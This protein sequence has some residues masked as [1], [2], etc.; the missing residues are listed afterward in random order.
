MI[1]EVDKYGARQIVTDPRRDMGISSGTGYEVTQSSRFRRTFGVM[2]GLLAAADR[3]LNKNTL[4]TLRELC[5]MHDRQSSLFSGMLDRGVVNIWGANFDFIPTTGDPELDKRVKDYIARRMDKYYA[6][7]SGVRD[8]TEIGQ[9]AL[10][11]IWND[12]DCLLIKR[13]DGSVMPVEADQIESP[14][15]LGYDGQSRRIVLGVELNKMNRPTAFHLRYRPVSGDSGLVR[16][17]EQWRRV[18]AK[19]GIYAAYRKRFNQTRGVPFLA[20]ILGTFDRTDNYLDYE[21]IAAE[22]GAM[23]GFKITKNELYNADEENIEDNDNTDSSFGKMQ[24]MEP[25]QIFELLVGE[26]VDMFGSQRP[27]SNFS[28]YIETCCRIMGVGLGMPLELVMM[29]FSKTNFSS[30]RASLGEARRGFRLWQKFSEGNIARP[31]YRWQINR[32][33]A[34]GELPADERLYTVRCQWPAWEYIDPVK[35]QQGNAIGVAMRVKSPQECIRERGG[36]PIEVVK[37]IG[38]FE[39]MLAEVGVEPGKV[40][41]SVATGRTVEDEE[42]GEEDKK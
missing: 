1:A 13:R 36:D 2:H 16:S 29:D 7:A 37:E 8:F 23:L 25:G 19:Y 33:I 24:K 35:E 38:E 11:A 31:W 40:R 20:S 30:S 34:L 5:R 26:D 9:T 4:G 41:V 28:S 10:R 6:D 42:E 22:I 12:G 39:K 21:Q 15:V 32:G 3:H 18:P 27:G 17:T 14:Q